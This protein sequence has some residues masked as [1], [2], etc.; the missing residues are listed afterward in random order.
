MKTKLISA[1]YNK[2]TISV[3]RN[4]TTAE[5]FAD[6]FM[7]LKK[8]GGKRKFVSISQSYGILKD[9]LTEK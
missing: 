4:R 1:N 2:E 5:S 3:D 6:E 7:K 8:Q 9:I